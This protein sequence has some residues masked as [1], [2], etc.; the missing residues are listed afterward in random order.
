MIRSSLAPLLSPKIK[1][2]DEI[3]IPLLSK[4]AISVASETKP[5]LPD[6]FLYK[7]VSSSPINVIEGAPTLPA[8][9]VPPAFR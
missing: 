5:T 2:P 3:V 4:L 1:L 8:G 7:P 6:P 9:F